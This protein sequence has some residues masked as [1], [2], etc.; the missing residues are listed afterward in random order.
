MKRLVWLFLAVFCTALAQ[1]QP[2]TLPGADTDACSCCDVPGS[3]DMP[4]CAP[5][6]SAPSLPTLAQAATTTARAEL[7]RAAK[8]SRASVEKFYFTFVK[9][10]P[11]PIVRFTPD[12][13]EPPASVPLFA[14]HCSYL[15]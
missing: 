4:D 8:P 9:S 5:P 6:A 11:R 13:M 10:S 14:T 15:I 1:V 12:R 3:C 2:V 7:R